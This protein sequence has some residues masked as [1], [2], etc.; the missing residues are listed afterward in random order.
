MLGPKYLLTKFHL[1]CL[2]Q[3]LA[4]TLYTARLYLQ[5]HYS[6]GFFWQFSWTTLRVNTAGT[7]LPFGELQLRSSYLFLTYRLPFGNQTDWTLE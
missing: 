4:K 2:V 5:P 3:V 7:Q 1:I 6:N